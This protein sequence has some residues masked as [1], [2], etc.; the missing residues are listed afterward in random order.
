MIDRRQFLTTGAAGLVAVSVPRA[1]PSVESDPLGVRAD[2]PI[3]RTS[4]YLN[5]AYTGPLSNATRRAAAEF[6]EDR[7]F[8]PAPGREQEKAESARARFAT[9]F[10][11]KP[12][13]VALLYSTSEGENIVTRS[14][15]LGAGD[16]VVIDELHFTTTFVLYRQLE[17]ELGIELRIV[18]HH[19]G[20]VALED[21]DAHIDRRTRLVSVA[22]VS[23][24]N[25]YRQDVRA[26]AALAHSH[27]A[28][29]YVDAIQAL[30]T[31]PADL[32]AEGIDFATAGSYKWFFGGFGV[33]PFYLREEHLDR[34]RPDRYGH[35]QVN[36][37]L[38]DFRFQLH[39]TSKKF[40]YAALATGS[41]YELDA[42]LSFL[43]NVGLDRIHQHGV[44]LAQ[45]LYAGVTR[46]G[47][48]V[49]TP[50]DNQSPIVTFAHGRDP[51]IVKRLLK[52]DG[53]D[54]T[55]RENDSQIRAS[56]ALFNNREDV[57]RLVQALA[58]VA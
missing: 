32:A 35:H 39:R 49:L 29:L 25:G 10:G 21:Y 23:N 28:F 2:F 6:I 19:D 15:G 40:E 22:W 1:S 20:R 12:Q 9:L 54:V 56:I 51:A 14:L 52:R 36:A 7:T 43:Q 46:L 8:R 48:R 57:H 17:Q 42:A 5:T 55:F 44:A 33:A 26:L 37:E 3:T 27:Q 41:V 53:I 13:Q 45:E 30:G 18:P 11:A 16:N 58:S 24:R 34:I 38:P 47:F 31:F 4:A 50:R